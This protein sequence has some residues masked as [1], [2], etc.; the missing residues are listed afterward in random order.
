M[1]TC[2]LSRTISQIS[3]IIGQI[4]TVDRVAASL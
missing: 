1:I 2:I 3:Q 4:L